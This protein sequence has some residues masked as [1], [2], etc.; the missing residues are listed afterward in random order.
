MFGAQELYKNVFLYGDLERLE[1]GKTQ[2]RSAL[3][4]GGRIRAHARPCAPPIPPISPDGRRVVFTLNDAGTRSIH[5]ADLDDEGLENARDRSCPRRSWSRRSRRAGRPTGRTS[6]TASGST[7][8]I[9][10]SATSTCATARY[11][12]SRTIA[13]STARPS[14]SA[15]GAFLY[16]HSDR[17]GI[18]N[19]YALRARDRPPPA[20]HER[21]HRR[22]HARAVAR[23]KDARVR[24]LHDGRASISSRCRSTS[25]RGPTPRR[26]VDD[27]PVAARSFTPKQWDVEA[28][29]P[30]AARSSRAATASRSPRAASVARSSMT[31][32]QAD[33]TGLHTV[34]VEHG[35]RAREA[36]APGLAR[37]H[38]RG[39]CRS[40]SG[41]ALPHPSRPAAATS[42]A[43]YQPTIVQE[44]T[45]F[46]STLAYSQADVLRLAARTSLT[47]SIARIGAD[48]P[49]AD[50]QA[51]SL[52]DAVIPAA[53]PREHAPHR[54]LVHERRALPL[55]RRP[56]AR[57]LARA[58][59]ST[60]PTRGSAAT[61]RA[62]SR[63]ATSPIYYLMPWL[64]HHSLAL[65]RRRGHERRVVPG[66]RR[67]LR[68][69]LR[70][71]AARRHRPQR[72]SS[73]AA[74][75][76]AAIHP[77]IDAGRSYALGNVEYRF[78][79][80][81]IDRGAVDA[82]DLPEPHHRR[83]LRRL[84]QRVRP[85]LD[86]RAVQDRH[87]RRALVRH[88]PSATSPPSRSASATRE[89]SRA[90]AST[91]STSSPPSRTDAK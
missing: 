1:P 35:D 19:I 34:A 59:R 71:P 49:D 70:R 16:F 50:R 89:G 38:L 91:R 24:R 68:R 66:A 79:I 60:S 69:Q 28:V 51:R 88:A 77:V 83:R 45:G 36:G 18:T 21:A 26:Y 33:V 27:A 48:I 42:S 84:R 74:S 56:G 8:A 39:A 6:R 53:R 40:T 37:L 43:T 80:V 57:L 29:Q 65:A 62:S 47:Q 87:R 5:I 22:V 14:F 31:A 73:R 76:C 86:T 72:R 13:P 64:E 25:R 15:D 75:R 55:E 61:S 58:R 9:A 32:A 7:A 44:T 10:T 63:T 85:A 78:P 4:D 23:R 12:T 52:R 20:G 17:T 30:V 90:A 67:V 11:A 82:A 46:A 41:F 2:L 3:P 54:L 81:N